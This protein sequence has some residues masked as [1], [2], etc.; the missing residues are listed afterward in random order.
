[1][2]KLFP[3]KIDLILVLIDDGDKN[4]A[5]KISTLYSPTCPRL[6]K[7]ISCP[8]SPFLVIY[9]PSWNCT[10]CVCLQRARIKGTSHFMN[11]GTCFIKLPVRSRH[12]SPC[13]QGGRSL[14]IASL[15]Q[16][17]KYEDK[18]F[19]PYISNSGMIWTLL[20][21][22]RQ[23]KGFSTRLQSKTLNFSVKVFLDSYTAV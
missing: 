15:L 12:N 16:P 14:K 5:F 8:I 17:L 23:N 4:A 21:K 1:M 11:N 2:Q 6:I 19:N 10:N 7:Y 13:K 20:L 3:W 18:F 9:S 22:I